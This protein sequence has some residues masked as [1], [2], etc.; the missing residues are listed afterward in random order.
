M[1][2]TL[3]PT[4]SGWLAPLAFNPTR[5][6]E[7]LS[8]AM[9]L[10]GTWVGC[11]WLVGG[12]SYDA[13]A[14]LQTAVARVCRM[15]LAAMPV[16]A[17]Q[18][19]LLTAA[20]DG[21]LVGTEGV[22]HPWASVLP[23][24]ASGPGEPFVTAG[25]VL[26]LLS[27]WRAFYC[28]FLD[29][30]SFRTPTGAR[31]D[32]SRDAAH[33]VSALRAA[34]TLS[35]VF[36]LLLWG[37]DA[38]ERFAT[39]ARLLQDVGRPTNAGEHP[40]DAGASRGANSPATAAPSPAQPPPQLPVPPQPLSQLETVAGL[41]T[42]IWSVGAA[43]VFVAGNEGEETCAAAAGPLADA[44]PQELRQL[45]PRALVVV[46]D[47]AEHDSLRGAPLV[48][49]PPHVRFFAGAHLLAPAGAGGGDC[50]GTGG[51]RQR[52][53]TLVV[54]DSEP[55]SLDAS[56][57][58]TLASFA[59]LA[60]RDAARDAAR[61]ANAAA[62]A[63]AAAGAA[64]R[65]AAEAAAL[66]AL[67]RQACALE[68]GAVLIDTRQP[69]WPILFANGPWAAATGF[70]TQELARAS[71]WQLFRPWVAA[72]PPAASGDSG[73]SGAGAWSST[74][75][76]VLLASKGS[77]A[78]LF[79]SALFDGTRTTLMSTS[80]SEAGDGGSASSGGGGV[81]AAAAALRQA[82]RDAVAGG[83]PMCLR[84]VGPRKQRPLRVSLR[85]GVGDGAA[86]AEDAGAAA[87]GAPSPTSLMDAP[88]S[89]SETSA[90]LSA[91][92]GRHLPADGG[93][94]T[95]ASVARQAAAAAAPPEQPA[96]EQSEQPAP[97][98]PEAAA[99]AAAGA[100]FWFV[101]A[102][103]AGG[104]ARSGTA[105]A[106]L[107]ASGRA[108]SAHEASLS[109]LE[110]G[111]VIGQGSFGRVHRALWRGA[112]VAV[113]EPREDPVS[114]VGAAGSQ[115]ALL[116]ACLS[117][118]LSHP[119][120]IQTFHY[121]VR[122]LEEI[123]S[124]MAYLHDQGIIHGDLTGGNVLLSSSMRDHRRF[125][126]QVSDFGLARIEAPSGGAHT[127]SYGTVSHMPPELLCE[128]IV[129]KAV[130]VYSYGVLLWAL[131]EACLSRDREARPTFEQV[132]KDVAALL[133][134]ESTAASDGQGGYHSA[135]DA[136]AP[137]SLPRHASLDSPASVVAPVRL[138]LD[139]VTSPFAAAA[140]P[141]A[142]LLPPRAPRSVS[143][144]SRPFLNGVA[145]PFAAPVT[146]AAAS[147]SAI[148]AA[149]PL[150]GSA[151]AAAGG[152]T[153]APD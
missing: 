77:H 44:L 15:W 40:S 114:S 142:A 103:G 26:G 146:A 88:V 42:T 144:P 123:A 3:L 54:L 128:G 84:V 97:E 86:D 151:S 107:Q 2:L 139:G 11:G 152:G 35:A 45:M 81:A 65:A 41:L 53:G 140:G 60:A 1:A 129:S 18:L 94:P 68:E 149:A 118:N 64:A 79:D 12:F 29:F 23:L 56:Q 90:A 52:L 43:L 136:P 111:P 17:A 131:C 63:V 109:E 99:A 130:D 82:A 55:R 133:A 138:S 135:F 92:T 93:S 122:H 61:R 96:P 67:L 117:R 124:A 104:P 87:R 115:A 59:D 80:G 39:P 4:F 36:C 108:A 76:A 38:V 21:S 141:G 75:S 148:S 105:G 58:E 120:I 143:P 24:A 20:E 47:A 127:Y 33:F 72:D 30:Y 16:A 126:A 112:L 48:A 7:L 74:S 22:L 100:P 13:T 32:R 106:G 57:R 116:E 51:L 101:L 125:T 34:A 137:A 71:F 147:P 27:I 46:P 121:A 132:A 25:G 89:T 37:L 110:L 119:N 153:G 19:V 5:F 113:L 95:A 69:D 50:R 10:V 8:F 98:R 145:S 73:V 83:L 134:A 28:S 49:G 66:Q 9:T 150:D 14:D 31:V 78:A 91:S 6:L 62:A 85:P 70:S 102:P